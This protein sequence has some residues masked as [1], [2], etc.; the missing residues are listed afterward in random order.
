MHVVRGL[1]AC[2]IAIAMGC[3]YVVLFVWEENSGGGDLELPDGHPSILGGGS[4]PMGYESDDAEK[5]V[6]ITC[7]QLFNREWYDS[8]LSCVHK[9]RKNRDSTDVDG[10]MIDDELE[11]LVLETMKP[12]EDA[13]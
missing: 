12:R 1:G 9:R 4:C 6:R 3:L 8:A 2:L 11:N 7:E 13:L 5:Q 10:R